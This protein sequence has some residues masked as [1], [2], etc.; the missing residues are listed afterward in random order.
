[1]MVNIVVTG[2]LNASTKAILELLNENEIEFDTILHK[3][4]HKNIL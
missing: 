2:V 4:L 3:D 1:M